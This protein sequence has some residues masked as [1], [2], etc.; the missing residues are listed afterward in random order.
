MHSSK[1]VAFALK[2]TFISFDSLG[3]NFE[4][5]EGIAYFTELRTALKEK[6]N[7]PDSFVFPL[8]CYFQTE[9]RKN[10]HLIR[11]NYH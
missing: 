3:N 8:Q 1:N 11:P 4:Y 2:K 5:S 10:S 7:Y 9:R 6:A